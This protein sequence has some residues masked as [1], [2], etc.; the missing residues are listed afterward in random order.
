VEGERYFKVITFTLLNEMSAK[1]PRLLA[2]INII[3]LQPA[4]N[5]MFFFSSQKIKKEILR[6]KVLRMTRKGK[7]TKIFKTPLPNV[8]QVSHKS[9]F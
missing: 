5:L 2:K 6:T 1:C 4:K 7:L 9:L 3:I 8:L